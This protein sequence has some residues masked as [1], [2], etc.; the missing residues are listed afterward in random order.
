MLAEQTIYRIRIKEV[1]PITRSG[2]VQEI[3]V[4][5]DPA[6]VSSST[7]SDYHVQ[8]CA[9]DYLP[10]QSVEG[11]LAAHP[12]IERD[13]TRDSNKRVAKLHGFVFLGKI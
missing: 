8:R 9:G 1:A 11:M 5:K 7:T 2:D 3:P 4:C 10:A 13:A 12:F 6:F